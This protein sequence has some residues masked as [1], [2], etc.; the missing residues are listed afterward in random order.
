MRLLKVIIMDIT[1]TTINIIIIM[2][3]INKFNF[4]LY[5]ESK[6]Y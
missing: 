1:T 5:S 4:T 2:A 6:K 3:K